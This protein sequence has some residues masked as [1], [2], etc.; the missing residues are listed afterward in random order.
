MANKGGFSWK[1]ATGITRMKQGISRTTGIPMTKSGRQRKAG[2][3]LTGGGCLV[4]TLTFPILFI[5]FITLVSCG[6]NAKDN[7]GATTSQKSDISFQT[8]NTILESTP[9]PQTV[10]PTPES[11]PS[12]QTATPTPESTPSPQTVTPTPEST[13][14]PQ[15]ATPTPENT[16]SPQTVTP[17]PESTP[18]PQ[19]AT[20]TPEST[21]SPQTATPTLESTPSPQ[22]ATPTP[23]VQT[24]ALPTISLVSITSPIGVNNTAILEIKGV[25]N[26]EYSIAVYYST[27]TSSASGLENKTS[28]SSGYV[29]WSWK[30]GARVKSGA[31]KIVINGGNESFTTYFTVIGSN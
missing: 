4:Q 25:P 16:P 30:V 31:Y 29:S 14:S 24:T 22:T 19:T 23:T 13:P 26:I 3:I 2:R 1:R 15:T 11:T 12:P 18:S 21:P 17:T 8:E 20:P 10:T 9:S 27:T 28:D 7:A 5:L 6:I